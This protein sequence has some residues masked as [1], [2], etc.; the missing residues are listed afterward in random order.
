MKMDI[1]LFYGMEL[2]CL[3]SRVNKAV[4]NTSADDKEAA[5]DGPTWLALRLKMITLLL[6]VLPDGPYPLVF[7]IFQ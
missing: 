6:H 4:S 5:P 7:R 2:L 1:I 3:R